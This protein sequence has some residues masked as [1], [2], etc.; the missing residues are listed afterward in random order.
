MENHFKPFRDNIIGINDRFNSPF[1]DVPLIYADW[2]AS[3]RLYRPIEERIINTMGP[4]I[5][6][7]HT[8][9]SETGTLM[10][11]AYHF[12]HKKIKEHVN[13]NSDDVIITAGFGMT[14]VVNKLQRMLG[15]KS[16]GQGSKI[17][18]IDEDNRPVVFITHMEHH[19]NHTSWFETMADVVQIPPGPDLLI[20]LDRFRSLL[21]Q[22]R[23]RRLKIGSFTACSNVTGIV[24]PYHQMARLMHEYGGYCFV[25]FAASAPYT[26]IDMHPAD[27]MEKL[28]AIFFSPHKF[29]GG[30][31][32]S[33]VLVFDRRLYSGHRP[34]DQPG[35]G[36]VDWTN[37]WGEYKYIDDIEAR[38]DG[39][40]PGF[41][42]A[43]KAALAIELKEK[44]GMDNMRKRE[45]ELLKLAFH[46]LDDI[47]GL[48]LLAENDRDRLGIIS[49]YIRDLHFNLVVKLLN[50]RFGIQVRGGCACAG[51]YGHYLL[52]VSYD[53][54]HLITS[55][56]S[57]GDLS[58][59]PGWIRLSLHPTMTVEELLY[60]TDAIRQVQANHKKWRD[61]YIYNR[62]TNE[63]RHRNEPEDKTSQ[64]SN[65]FEL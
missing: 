40:T 20:D 22:Y 51:T 2:I 14:A 19:S 58:Q 47:P 55:L 18:C 4:F 23:E 59:K 28:D 33:G 25:D 56:I 37:P 21:E 48:H 44:M 32:S 52:D 38:E 61:D 63:F 3:G 53:K 31:G 60:I 12:A 39:G 49:F 13:A 11:Y 1:G 9:T 24:T 34:P 50:D 17:N 30:P 8:E 10:T 16:C 27:P 54:S 57:S 26:A 42:Q 15:L 64:I 35:G 65:W 36:T 62:H 29:L 43:I 46:Q 41:L 5:G 6:N 45:E 7:T